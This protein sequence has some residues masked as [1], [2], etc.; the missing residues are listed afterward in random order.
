MLTFLGTVA[1]DSQGNIYVAAEGEAEAGG[2][3]FRIEAS[4]LVTLIVTGLKR[5]RGLVLTPDGQ[6]LVAAERLQREGE[7]QGGTVFQVN[8]EDGQL[9]P[10]IGPPF[11]N[12]HSVALDRLGSL[13]FSAEGQEEEEDPPNEDKGRLHKR[14]ADLSR[15]TR[16]R[17]FTPFQVTISVGSSM[18]WGG[19]LPFR[20]GT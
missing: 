6:L 10:L 4:G 5:P 9:I 16:R 15:P 12:P 2:S 18:W 3:L 19:N 14:F 8:L 7:P 11:K 20:N 1:V 17:S 13:F